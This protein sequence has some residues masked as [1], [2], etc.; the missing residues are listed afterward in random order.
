MIPLWLVALAL[1]AASAAAKNKQQHTI[2][3]R[4]NELAGQER[5]REAGRQ[6]QRDAAL[7]STLQNFQPGEQ[8]KQIEQAGEKRQ[9]TYADT[10]AQGQGVPGEFVGKTST[11]A[12][13]RTELASRVADYLSKGRTE[14]QNKAKLGAFGD[15]QFNNNVNVGRTGQQLDML[16]DFTRGSQGA[17]GM[18][19]TNAQHA[20]DNW[21]LFSDLLGAA[22]TG[23]SLYSFTQPPGAAAVPVNTDPT[24]ADKLWMHGNAT[25]T[26]TFKMR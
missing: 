3:D 13:V 24:M 21:G 18:E 26:P 2:I 12:E 6:T 10:S 9:Q 7:N 15:T 23:A 22:G 8:Q 14:M 11:P 25:G 16:G 19:M 4:Q 20:G 1:T 5:T 17:L